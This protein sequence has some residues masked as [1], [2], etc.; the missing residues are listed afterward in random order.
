[1]SGNYPLPP[2]VPLMP[3]QPNQTG[4]AFP[5]QPVPADL[6]LDKTANPA[7]PENRPY[8]GQASSETH[9]GIPTIQTDSGRAP[10]HS[11]LGPPF[12][13]ARASDQLNPTQFP[14]T[15]RPNSS[16]PDQSSASSSF[17]TC[18]PITSIPEEPVNQSYLVDTSRN[19]PVS[20]Q[21]SNESQP[22]EHSSRETSDESSSDQENI[23]PLP[24]LLSVKSPQN[25][26][27]SPYP[28]STPKALKKEPTVVKGRFKHP[29]LFFSSRKA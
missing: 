1:M 25:D 6:S 10:S 23:A 17:R 21:T 4:P 3:S 8:A 24:Q 15:L 5:G 28:L 11:Y 14:N 20:S 18:Q 16:N 29:H 19:Q 27:Y 26:Y 7:Y 9:P 12:N 22:V 2:E 13:E